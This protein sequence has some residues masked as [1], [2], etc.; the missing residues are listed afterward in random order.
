MKF[1]TLTLHDGTPVLLNASQIS[2][3]SRD[4][5]CP[6]LRC[7]GLI[8]ARDNDDFWHVKETVLEIAAML[9]P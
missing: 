1:I 6:D 8:N 5:E 9:R 7:L 4:D 2:D 3:I